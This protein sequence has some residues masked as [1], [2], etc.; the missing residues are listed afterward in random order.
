MKSKNKCKKFATKI[1]NILL[2]LQ[3][4]RGVDGEPGP[5]GVSGAVVS[6]SINYKTIKVQNKTCFV[7]HSLFKSLL[8]GVLM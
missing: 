1:I 7:S 2:Y 5:Q 3:G 6:S 8:S 4:P